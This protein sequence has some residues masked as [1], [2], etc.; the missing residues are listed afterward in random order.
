MVTAEDVVGIYQ[1]LLS[2][3]IQVWLT[4]GWGIDALLGEQTRPHKDLDLIM[5]VDDVVQMLELLSDDSFFL[6]E[7]WSENRW[8]VDARGS[9]T[10]TAVVLKDSKGREVDLHAMRLDEQGRGFPAW[11]AD[12]FVFEADDLAGEGMIVGFHVQCLA[13]ATQMLLHTGYELPRHQ[14]RDLELLHERF[15]VEYPEEHSHLRRSRA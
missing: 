15:G 9:K 3:E 8:V 7:V 13:P 12:R 11:D 10:A 2:A 1:R 6:K 5:L 14:V 4:G